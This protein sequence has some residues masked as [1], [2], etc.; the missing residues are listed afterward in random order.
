MKN[1]KKFFVTLDRTLIL[2]E[3]PLRHP[4]RSPAEIPLRCTSRGFAVRLRV[5]V[6]LSEA[7]R[8]RMGLATLRSE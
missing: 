6:T 1:Y 5:A 4:E 8:N 2:S 3:A 7:K